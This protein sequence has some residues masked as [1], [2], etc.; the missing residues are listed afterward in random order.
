MQELN[1]AFNSLTILPK[2]ILLLTNLK[3]INLDNNQFLNFPSI[4][5]QMPKLKLVSLLDN[6]LDIEIIS[7]IKADFCIIF[8]DPIIEESDEESSTISLESLLD[9]DENIEII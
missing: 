7:N 4:L 3:I 2:E 6:P 9:Y 5:L 8:E 1:L